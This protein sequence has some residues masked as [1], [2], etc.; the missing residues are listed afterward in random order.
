M[1]VSCECCVLSGRYLCDGLITPLEDS[2]RRWCVFVCD[3]E[4]S[5]MRRP[6]PTGDCCAKKKLLTRRKLRVLRRKPVPLRRCPP[7][8]HID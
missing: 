2:Y 8:S 7:K 3:L 6:W 1:F 5:G 4:T